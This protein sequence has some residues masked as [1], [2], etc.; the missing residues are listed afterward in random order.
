[1]PK[2]KKRR[3][4]IVRLQDGNRAPYY[5][6]DKVDDDDTVIIGHKYV[7]DADKSAVRTESSGLV[8]TVIKAYGAE[9]LKKGQA[10][11]ISFAFS[12]EYYDHVDLTACH[13]FLTMTYREALADQY[14]NRPER[15]YPVTFL[16]QKNL[17]AL[18]LLQFPS[19]A[20]SRFEGA[21][22]V[23]NQEYHLPVED[24]TEMYKNV[25]V[26][27]SDARSEC[28]RRFTETK[29]SG[30]PFYLNGYLFEKQLKGNKT[31]EEILDSDKMV[32]Y[33]YEYVPL[34]TIEII[35]RCDLDNLLKVYLENCPRLENNANIIWD[36]ANELK[37]EKCLQLLQ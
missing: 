5:V 37:A 28:L 17:A 6:M 15:I 18:T 1:M 19:V 31:F 32:S 12:D 25:I 14:T 10:T 20:A 11:E 7:F 33:L 26:S 27:V 2:G 24:I 29:L 22:L 8:G 23:L 21:K 9:S 3:T 4:V 36:M 35:L 13:K 34:A 30:Y 16:M